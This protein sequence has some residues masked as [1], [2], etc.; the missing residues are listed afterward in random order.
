MA[1]QEK[2]KKAMTKDR[3]IGMRVIDS[4]GNDAGTVQDIAFTVGKVGMTMIVEGKKGETREI[5]WEEIQAAGDF[6]LLKPSGTQ[7]Q[8]ASAQPLGQQ[9]Q[10]PT[11]PTCGGPLTWIPQYQR[12]YCYKDKK[13]A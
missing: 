6:V 9:T 1:K 11:C 7:G 12:W 10:T 3:L 5:P 4:E 8:S 2:E 13:Y